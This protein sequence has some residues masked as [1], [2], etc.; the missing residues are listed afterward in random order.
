MTPSYL[1][2]NAHTGRPQT[3]SALLMCRIG[4]DDKRGKDTMKLRTKQAIAGVLLT[5]VLASVGTGVAFATTTSTSSSTSGSSLSTSASTNTTDPSSGSTTPAEPGATPAG[6][7]NGTDP[8]TKGGNCPG[9]GSSSGSSS[10]S[11]S[12]SS[13]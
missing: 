2:L 1:A 8:P 10:D 5:G 4:C 6:A 11:G 13:S 12:S 3:D 7:A 9:M